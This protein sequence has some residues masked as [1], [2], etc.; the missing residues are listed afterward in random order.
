MSRFQK[1]TTLIEIGDMVDAVRNAAGDD[2]QAHGLEDEARTRVLEALADGEF[3]LIDS[4]KAARMI[5][6]TAEI[7]F[8]RWCA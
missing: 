1:P 4:M 8:A 3:N 5:L 2:E 6:R 7:E